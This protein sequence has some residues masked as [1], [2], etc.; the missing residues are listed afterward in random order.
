MSKFSKWLCVS[1]ITLVATAPVM[2]GSDDAVPGNNG[3]G[4][5]ATAAEPVPSPALNPTSAI[6]NSNVTALLG[7]LVMKGVLAPAEANAIQGA[8]PEAEFQLLVEALTKK[9]L[10]SAADV[11]AAPEL[12]G[13]AVAAPEPAVGLPQAASSASEPADA[14]TRP[15][16]RRRETGCREDAGCR[17]TTST[18]NL[19]LVW[20]DNTTTHR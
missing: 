16:T 7:V 13:A 14:A 15:R 4:T 18:P 20:I 3:T 17:T 19:H 10:L 11:A 2:A 12:A 6:S 1:L 8:A 5:N 9:G